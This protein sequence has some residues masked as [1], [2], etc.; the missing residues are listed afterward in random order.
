MAGDYTTRAHGASAAGPRHDLQPPAL[1]GRHLR[2]AAGRARRPPQGGGDLRPATT[3]T[4]I[5]AVDRRLRRA[6]RALRLP[7]RLRP[8]QPV[9]E[10][11]VHA[12]RRSC[13]STPGPRSSRSRRAPRSS[14]RRPMRSGCRRS[15]RSRRSATAGS[16]PRACC[17]TRSA[18]RASC[19]GSSIGVRGFRQA[20]DDQL[21]TVFGA[22]RSGPPDRRRRPLQRGRGGR[23]PAAGLGRP[24]RACAVAVRARQ[25]RLRAGRDRLGAAVGGQSAAP[26]QPS[27]RARCASRTNGCTT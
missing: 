22:G 7:R 11:G 23:C 18:R 5:A 19:A 17:S 16:R 1:R 21:V 20:I 2:G 13:A 8:G 27:R 14:C 25:R 6:L 10:G 24:G 26:W 15:A 9:G 4:L 3:S 12:G